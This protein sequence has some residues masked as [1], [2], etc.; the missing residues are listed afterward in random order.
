MLY[1]GD[2][3]LRYYVRFSQIRSH[4][5]LYHK[6]LYHNNIYHDIDKSGEIT[7]IM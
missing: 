6:S 2:F 7:A 4:I 1:T 3:V 5:H